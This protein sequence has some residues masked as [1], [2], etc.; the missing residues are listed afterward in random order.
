MWYK[1]PKF[2]LLWKHGEPPIAWGWFLEAS[3]RSRHS[4]V[5][6]IIMVWQT[7]RDAMLRSL[8]KKATCSAVKTVAGWQLPPVGTSRIRPCIVAEVKL[9]LGQWLSKVAV[10]GPSCFWFIQTSNSWFCSGVFIV[11]METLI[12]SASWIESS[13]PNSAFALFL[14]WV[15]LP[16]YLLHFWLLPNIC[17]W[18]DPTDANWKENEKCISGKRNNVRTDTGTCNIGQHIGNEETLV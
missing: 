6:W 8:Y 18:D 16:I 9:F 3:H 1:I 12:R 2:A 11:Q 17:F 10:Q 4:N 15:L 5:V 14:S 13:W 7:W